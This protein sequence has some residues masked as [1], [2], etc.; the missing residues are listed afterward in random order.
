MVKIIMEENNKRVRESLN[1]YDQGSFMIG[2]SIIQDSGVYNPFDPKTPGQSLHGDH[3]YVFYQ[4]PVNARPLPMVFIHGNGQ[5]KKTWETTPDGRDGFQNIFLR[6]KFSVYLADQP[7]RG[8]AGRACVSMQIQAMCD[9]QSSLFNM[10]RIG[11]WPEYFPGVQFSRSPECLNQLFRSATPNTGDFD[12][13]VISDAFAM[14]FERIGGGILVSHSRGG[15]C[16]WATVMKSN[17]I[18]GVVAF[19]PGS[20]FVFPEGE[21][22]E[23]MSSSLGVLEAIEIPLERFMALTRIPIVVYYAD[24]IPDTPTNHYGQ[25]MWRVRREMTKKFVKCINNH[26]GDAQFI[27]LPELG[28]YGN[29]HFAFADLNNLQIADLVSDYLH[30][31]NLD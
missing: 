11:R 1:I 29:T 25:D 13:D 16:G 17:Y 18:K 4:I 14:L 8:E 20:N 27:S 2:G 12:L 5:S 15:G 21:L 9:D 3:A 19:E 24:N 6:R 22:P 23:P 30:E 28:I 10:F 31:K 7:R 26:G